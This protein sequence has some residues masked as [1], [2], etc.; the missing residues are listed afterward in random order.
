[1]V[2]L[3]AKIVSKSIDFLICLTD[4]VDFQLVK[5]G[6]ECNLWVSYDNEKP[7]CPYEDLQTYEKAFVCA[8]FAFKY[9]LENCGKPKEA[10]IFNPTISTPRYHRKI[11]V[12]SIEIMMSFF[13]NRI[14]IREEKLINEIHDFIGSL[15]GSLGMF[16]GFSIISWIAFGVDN[17]FERF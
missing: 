12:P 17:I 1:M 16:F 10:L 8:D 5:C 11:Q 6:L 3:L 15:G 13:S 14:Q 2:T 9:Y 4:E 7:M